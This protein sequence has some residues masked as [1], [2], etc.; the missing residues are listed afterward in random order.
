MLDQTIGVLCAMPVEAELLS[1]QLIDAETPGPYAGVSCT[2]GRIGAYRVVIAV[3]G[4]G[5]VHAAMAS[6]MMIDRFSVTALINS[7]IA[8][9]LHPALRQLELV[10]STRTVQHDF[11][12]S[13][14]DEPKGRIPGCSAPGSVTYFPADEGLLAAFRR[15][16]ASFPQARHLE[17]TIASGDVFVADEA[18]KSRLISTFD[19]AAAEMEGAAVA[20]VAQAN[21]VPYLVIRAISD[22]AGEGAPLSYEA[23]EQKAAELSAGVVLEM[24]RG[25]LDV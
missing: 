10:A 25:G 18:L 9:G 12:L 5:K 19:A 21:G 20:Q 3:S 16:M 1:R 24:L 13:A 14:M 4:I 11:D 17:G 6:Q 22:L 23:F 7:G 8:G 2:V 15:A